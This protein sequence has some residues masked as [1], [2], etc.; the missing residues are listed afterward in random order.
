MPGPRCEI[1]FTNSSKVETLLKK[2]DRSVAILCHM[3][4]AS[5]VLN[6]LSSVVMGEDVIVTV[7][8]KSVD[9]PQEVKNR[10]GKVLKKQ[11][12]VVEDANGYG[13]VV[14]WV[15][16]VGKMSEGGCYKLTGVTARSFRG[17]NYLS[18]G[19]D[20]EIVDMEV[21]ECSSGGG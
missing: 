3:E 18:V 16:D 13:Q 1:Q 17:A 14:L 12:C 20:C 10:E 9:P 8:V 7:K 4:P 11:D 21:H 15:G 19:K 5:I 2:F 6:F